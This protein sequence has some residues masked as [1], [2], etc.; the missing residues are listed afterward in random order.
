MLK[1]FVETCGPGAGSRN[2][3]VRPWMY[4]TL[5][6]SRTSTVGGTSSRSNIRSDIRAKVAFDGRGTP[7]HVPTSDAFASSGSH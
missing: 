6:C 5:P 3:P 7:H 2:I 4:T 1:M